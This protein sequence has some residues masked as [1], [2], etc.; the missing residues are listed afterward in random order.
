LRQGLDAASIM[1][2]TGSPEREHFDELRST[3]GL[4]AALAWRKALFAPYE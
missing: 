1:R 2:A 3:E 4:A